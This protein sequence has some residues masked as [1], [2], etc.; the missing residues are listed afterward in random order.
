MGG[1]EAELGDCTSGR[2]S[3]LWEVNSAGQLVNKYNG[4]CM[5]AP[6]DALI[7]GTCSD[8]LSSTYWI[9]TA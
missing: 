4:T 6:N 2:A 9:G 3:Q 7:D 5:E 8:H 1:D